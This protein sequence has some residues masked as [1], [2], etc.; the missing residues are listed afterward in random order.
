MAKKFFD[1][2]PEVDKK[3]LR[4]SL[5]LDGSL[6]YGF[7]FTPGQTA[8]TATPIGNMALYYSN[9]INGLDMIYPA[10]VNEGKTINYK[11]DPTNLTKK[12]DGS[13]SDL[14]GTDGDALAI[15]EKVFWKKEYDQLRNKQ[16]VWF[17]R[18]QLDGFVEVPRHAVGIYLGNI[19][20]D[21]KLRSISGATP[22]TYKNRE[23]FRQAAALKGAGWCQEPYHMYEFKYFLAVLEM[24]NLNSQAALSTGATTASSTNWNNYN[25]YRP[26][27]TTDG[28]LASSYGAGTIT[29]TPGNPNAANIRNGE[30][31]IEVADFDGMTLSTQ[32]AIFHWQRDVFGHIWEWKEG[33]NLHNSTADGARAYICKDPANFADDT[34]NNYALYAEILQSDGYVSK[35]VKNTML[36][37][38]VGG[39]S[40][41]HCGDYHHTY[42]DDDPDIGFRGVFSGGSLLNGTYAGF[43]YL[44]GSPAASFRYANFGS[45]LFL[46]F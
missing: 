28:G 27:W 20:G 8:G 1:N 46:F 25:T 19:D 30:I 23:E 44:Y 39:S 11:L 3:A 45:R 41:N 5:G 7:E 33:I 10:V 6:K 26:I 12:I 36:P 16:Q 18:F 15:Y 24:L 31:P 4:T 17:S 43:A 21:G 32:M 42:Y 13:D 2:M 34:I 29:A 9:H 37:E 35:F 14:T 40:S 38:L 22:T